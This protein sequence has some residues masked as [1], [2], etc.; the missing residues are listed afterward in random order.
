MREYGRFVHVMLEC[1][2][3]K[4]HNMKSSHYAT[5]K[6][7]FDFSASFASRCL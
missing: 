2:L 5:S 7:N 4:M 3:S 1:A 6:P